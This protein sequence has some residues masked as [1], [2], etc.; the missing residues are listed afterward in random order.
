[1][2]LS[3]NF[4]IIYKKKFETLI[5]EAVTEENQSL[6]LSWLAIKL[7]S[8]TLDKLKSLEEQVAN[9]QKRQ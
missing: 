2:I 5:G 8:M 3:T 7:S 6:Y 1:M 9:L 4:D